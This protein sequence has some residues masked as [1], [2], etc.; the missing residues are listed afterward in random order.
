MLFAGGVLSP[1]SGFF[2]TLFFLKR[3]F[4]PDLEELG[5]LDFKGGIAAVAIPAGFSPAHRAGKMPA[6][7][8]AG[9]TRCG[10]YKVPALG[11]FAAAGNRL[12]SLFVG[13]APA[14][15]FALIPQLFSFGECEFHFHP[16]VLEVHARGNKGKSLLLGLTDQL[17]DFVFMDQQFA[18]TQRGMIEDVAVLVRTDVSIQQPELPVLDQAVGIFEVSEPGTDRFDLGA[19]QNDAGLKFFQQEVVM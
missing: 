7:R 1:G 19:G 14:F 18:R 8:D 10:R 15:G 3:N 11:V 16:A 9:A 6:L 12:A 13:S 4:A 2:R 5:V 17:A